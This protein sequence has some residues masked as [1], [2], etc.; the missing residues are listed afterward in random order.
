MNLGPY[1]LSLFDAV[2]MRKSMKSALYIVFETVI[3]QTNNTNAIYIIDGGYL[4]NRVVWERNNS[5]SVCT[6]LFWL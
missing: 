6:K 1:P 3:I 2:G 5:C 4:L